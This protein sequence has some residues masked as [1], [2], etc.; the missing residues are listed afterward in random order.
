MP[1]FEKILPTDTTN[2]SHVLAVC[3]S[4]FQ[5]L[6]WDIR[7]ATENRLVAYTTSSAFSK[8]IEIIATVTPEGLHVSS[9]MINDELMDIKKKNQKNVESF[10]ATY[11]Q[12]MTSLAP[13]TI[14]VNN[15]AIKQLIADTSITAEQEIKEITELN[16]A[17]NLDK[18]SM[19]VT[20]VI[21]AANIVVFIL[22]IIQG[23]GILSANPLVH[24]KW[25]SN[26]GPLTMSG[27]WWRL[28]TAMFLHFG[29]IHLA[30][31]MYALFSI[32]AYL[33]PM[34]GKVRYITAYLCSGILASLLSL[35]WH[36]E[37]INSAG[38]SG[39]VFGMYGVFLALLT[40][41]IIPKSMRNALL[42]SIVVFVIFNLAYGLKGGID[43][44][45]HVG[46]LFSGMVIGYLFAINIKKEKSGKKAIWVI[47]AIVIISVFVC[48]Y[49]LQQNK[50]TLEE[51]AP[52][53]KFVENDGSFEL[54]RFNEL[55]QQFN[56]LN[57]NALKIYAEDGNNLAV[58]YNK[59]VPIW[60]QADSISSLI[61]KLN[62]NEKLQNKA[63]SIDYYI[64]LRKMEI[65]IMTNM[66]NDPGKEMT[67][68]RQ[69]EIVRQ[70]ISEELKKIK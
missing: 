34:L 61:L 30:L 18:G 56:N 3:Y 42:Q 24:I 7:Y 32:A 60:D 21:I 10:L 5:L 28:F 27:D 46:G 35:W 67:Y 40:T 58:L 54:D 69:R 13:A 51:R 68:F 22:M 57:Q 63:T 45:A 48:G 16:E 11:E 52:I 37:P 17:L 9:E 2:P 65:E 41:N 14:E 29:I 44:A 38:A 36:T 23:A 55:F 8:S 53:V 64:Q 47:P 43:N 39:A 70:R 20:Y 49:Y 31:N 50:V 19:S 4:S 33:E 59:A 62:L 25:G 12:T 1:R 66:I 6:N 15:V 26:F